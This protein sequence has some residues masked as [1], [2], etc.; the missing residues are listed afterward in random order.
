MFSYSTYAN[1][2]NRELV[3]MQRCL[4]DNAISV[5]DDACIWQAPPPPPTSPGG[6]FRNSAY[7]FSDKM[8]QNIHSWWYLLHLQKP[9]SL[10]RNG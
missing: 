9:W 7:L 5:I 1:I 4:N 8:R 6:M 3:K 2:G 10:L